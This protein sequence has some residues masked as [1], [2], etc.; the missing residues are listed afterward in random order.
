MQRLR[1]LGIALMIILAL[2]ALAATTASAE[3]PEILPAPTTTTPLLFT[4]SGGGAATLIPTKEEEK[5]IF[6]CKKIR[7]DGDFTSADSGTITIDLEEC[8]ANVTNCSTSGDAAGVILMDKADIN[9]VDY[10]V[11]AELLPGVVIEPLEGGKSILKFKCGILGV[12]VKGSMLGKVSGVKNNVKTKTAKL[13]Y[14]RTKGEQELTKCEL[15]KAFCAGK[16]F[17]LEQ[18]FGAAGFELAGEEA[19]YNVTFAK[20]AEI[21]F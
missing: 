4:S 16:E 1:L 20:E 3:T 12:E 13:E 5:T 9:L 15:L 8:K 14:K 19:E 11:G 7:S 17:K 18:S 2:T 6:K 21:H 10:K